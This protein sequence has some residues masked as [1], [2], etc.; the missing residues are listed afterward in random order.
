MKLNFL[1]VNEHRSETPT[2]AK[3]LM[4]EHV[5]NSE[6]LMREVCSG[7]EVPTQEHDMKASSSERKLLLT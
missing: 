1:F 7:L 4:R 3:A 5:L 2:R 6:A